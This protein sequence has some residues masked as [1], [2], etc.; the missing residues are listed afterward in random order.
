M[1]I[2]P[3]VGDCSFASWC[4][5]DCSADKKGKVTWVS[6][7]G[8]PGGGYCAPNCYTWT[9]AKDV[10]DYGKLVPVIDS[11]Y[12]PSCICND[13]DLTCQKCYPDSLPSDCPNDTVCTEWPTQ[14]Q[15]PWSPLLVGITYSGSVP[16]E[17]LGNVSSPPWFSYEII[18]GLTRS[19]CPWYVPFTTFYNC[20][21]SQK[22]SW[23]M[24]I[25]FY[26][27]A[28]EPNQIFS[29]LS[30]GP[31]VPSNI[32]PRCD[33][34]NNYCWAGHSDFVMRN[35]LSDNMRLGVDD[36][37]RWFTSISSYGTKTLVNRNGVF[38]GNS[39]RGYG[40]AHTQ[41]MTFSVSFNENTINAVSLSFT[42][43]VG[44]TGYAAVGP[45]GPMGLSVLAS[46]YFMD[47][48][49]S[50]NT[51]VT[52][53]GYVNNCTTE[54]SNNNCP[55]YVT[56]A[57]VLDWIVNS[58]QGVGLYGLKIPT[59]A[60]WEYACRAGTQTAFHG[61]AKNPIGT[62]SSYEASQFISW[63]AG[64]PDNVYGASGT[65]TFFKQAT[66]PAGQ[67]KPNGLGFHD[68]CG[69][70]FGEWDS[71]NYLAYEQPDPGSSILTDP[72]YPWVFNVGVAAAS[73]R[74]YRYP[75]SASGQSLVQGYMRNTCGDREVANFSITQF[76]G[77]EPIQN[78][79]AFRVSST[80][81]SIDP[82]SIN[83]TF[84]VI[85]QNPDPTVVTDEALRD[86]ITAT[87]L[88]WRVYHK[89]SAFSTDT[90]PRYAIEMLLVPPGEFIRGGVQ[91]F[92]EDP[93]LWC[94]TGG[95]GGSINFC[96][97]TNIRNPRPNDLPLQTVRITKPFYLSR[98][99]ITR[100]QFS[101]ISDKFMFDE[102]C[103]PTA[104][105]WTHNTIGC[106]CSNNEFGNFCSAAGCSACTDSVCKTLP[107]CCVVGGTW[108][109]ACASKASS[110]WTNGGVGT[111]NP[112]GFTGKDMIYYPAGT[113][114]PAGALCW[115]Y[116]SD[117]GTTGEGDVF[118][119]V[120]QNNF[121]GYT[122]YKPYGL[123]YYS[124]SPKGSSAEVLRNY[125]NYRDGVFGERPD[126][127]LFR[128][129]NNIYPNSWMVGFSGCTAPIAMAN[130]IEGQ[131][132]CSID[133][134]KCNIENYTQSLVYYNQVAVGAR[135]ALVTMGE[136][137][138]GPSECPI[139]TF[140][141][142]IQ[143]SGQTFG[144]IDVKPKW[145][146]MNFNLT[147]TSGFYSTRKLITGSASINSIVTGI[148]YSDE[149]DKLYKHGISGETSITQEW[150][151]ENDSCSFKN[152]NVINPL[153]CGFGLT[154]CFKYGITL[155][156]KDH[157]IWNRGVNDIPYVSVI[158]AKS[159]CAQLHPDNVE[160]DKCSW[161]WISAGNTGESCAILRCEFDDGTL[162]RHAICWGNRYDQDTI[163][164]EAWDTGMSDK[165]VQEEGGY[166][167]RNCTD[168]S[169][170]NTYHHCQI[171]IKG[172]SPVIYYRSYPYDLVGHRGSAKSW[173]A[174][175]I[176]SVNTYNIRGKTKYFKNGWKLENSFGDATR[177][178]PEY[179]NTD[180]TLPPT[181]NPV[182]D[183]Q[184]RDL[185]RNHV[186][187]YGLEGHQLP[188]MRQTFGAQFVPNYPIISSN[189]WIKNRYN[190][191][192]YG[193]ASGGECCSFA[194]G[195]C[196][197]DGKCTDTDNLNCS[198]TGGDCFKSGQV[199]NT[200]ICNSC[201]SSSS[202]SSSSSG[203]DCCLYFTGPCCKPD[204]TC[205][206]LTPMECHTANGIFLGFGHLC[207]ECDTL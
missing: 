171:D 149:K 60:Q 127:I 40:S 1:P 64:Y 192:S 33:K 143:F 59:G 187:M 11:S 166:K 94:D 13:G 55:A 61:W 57:S 203:K 135:H 196:C 133:P 125:P 88:P 120:W 150:D 69:N 99:T 111:N 191:A 114:F 71:D 32:P 207:G 102:T 186:E 68:M 137:E 180:G 84:G 169:V 106:T 176:T 63:Y 101:A 128:L 52:Y 197:K 119:S 168:N 185:R 175:S 178:S 23:T 113:A 156:H 18:P 28:I 145:S 105:S 97:S 53:E 195:V 65:P 70:V 152:G 85:E 80:I 167:E 89:P 117:P 37:Q 198:E 95:A 164:A 131:T 118:A 123:D 183:I 77:G 140:P 46:P 45:S 34:D 193:N 129:A 194:T 181:S 81:D 182:T 31:T 148:S 204:D 173:I 126:L 48:N 172:S 2:G 47:G 100:A 79:G 107:D 174:G 157:P 146:T 116:Y 189:A 163:P 75:T 54:H 108:S 110:F 109:G 62:D 141:Y 19:W 202:S 67:K 72:A 115:S 139:K 130:R 151:I 12:S 6:L 87:G 165:I 159:I 83:E 179:D 39:E 161:D 78:M 160:A 30:S 41:G 199:C 17:T 162:E 98:Y 92:D 27:K 122:D 138:I 90:K 177:I 205:E 142:L 43:I 103:V 25:T 56:L 154:S 9:S 147:P 136:Y 21:P 5:G 93:W 15:I 206:F 4:L 200:T 91:S 73:R 66:R 26:N 134:V 14:T 124:V 29:T 201:S 96:D 74:N 158:S 16:T 170:T 76:S 36:Q 35:G 22:D 82:L 112:S 121:A 3:S 42:H 184:Y 86:A 7:P 132:A 155:G 49:K 188:E 144:Q 104:T 44:G 153:L 10:G 24:G 190:S 51:Q 8:A 20:P 50:K 58:G 38:Y